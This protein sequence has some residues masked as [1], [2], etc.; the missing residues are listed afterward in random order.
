MTKITSKSNIPEQPTTQLAAG[1]ASTV[2]RLVV[3]L[4]I[5]VAVLF[6]IG[7]VQMHIQPINEISNNTTARQTRKTVPSTDT[8]TLHMTTQSTEKLAP[9]SVTVTEGMPNSTTNNIGDINASAAAQPTVTSLQAPAVTSPS[10][11]STLQA[12]KHTDG[13]NDLSELL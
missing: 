7:Y 12:H 4:P 13:L 3:T 1:A 9:L 11:D 10:N 8:P 2:R 5:L 6:T